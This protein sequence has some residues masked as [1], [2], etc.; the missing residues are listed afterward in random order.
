MHPYSFSRNIVA[1]K[2]CRDVPCIVIIPSL[3][4]IG[5]C[6]SFRFWHYNL[7]V[8]V[9]CTHASWTCNFPFLCQLESMLF[10]DFWY[11]ISALPFSL[12]LLEKGQLLHHSYMSGTT[13]PDIYLQRYFWN[14]IFQNSMLL[15]F[16]WS[17]RPFHIILTPFFGFANTSFWSHFNPLA[18]R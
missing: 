15:F 14:A 9:G 2:R 6:I 13:C 18:S 1:W 7:G 4:S 17:K 11:L 16:L 12:L 8:S 10:T 5:K 3:V